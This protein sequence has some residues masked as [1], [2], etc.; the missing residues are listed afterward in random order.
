M[1]PLAN[2]GGG[3]DQEFR[4][5]AWSSGL[6]LWPP[7]LGG[8]ASFGKLNQKGVAGPSPTCRPPSKSSKSLPASLRRKPSF[9]P[10]PLL[11]ASWATR[12]P[13]STP[14]WGRTSSA[15]QP[16]DDDTSSVFSGGGSKV[17]CAPPSCLLAA[18]PHGFAITNCEQRRFSYLAIGDST[19]TALYPPGF[20]CSAPPPRAKFPPAHCSSG[21][22]SH[23]VPVLCAVGGD[24]EAA[25]EAPDDCQCALFHPKTLRV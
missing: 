10:G 2:T 23:G 22:N 6:F 1:T 15:P 25:A 21:G 19:S 11:E 4:L 13:S 18:P 8:M 12:E 20:T 14:S 5:T 17:R 16:W 7:S 3:P 24:G 9:A